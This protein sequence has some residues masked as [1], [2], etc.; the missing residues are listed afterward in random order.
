MRA[1][2]R[3]DFHLPPNTKIATP[4]L[5]WLFFHGVRRYEM[6]AVDINCDSSETS[7]SDR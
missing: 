4:N 3:G 2:I 5:G 6:V 7:T 1:R